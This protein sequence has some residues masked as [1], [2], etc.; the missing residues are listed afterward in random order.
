MVDQ[1]DD[2]AW[3]SQHRAE[4]CNDSSY[5]GKF[6]LIRDREILAAFDTCEEAVDKTR[7]PLGE[8]II[9]ECIPV[10]EEMRQNTIYKSTWLDD[11]LVP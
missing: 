1:E 7:I 11:C 2:Y 5:R 9:Q 4:W 6:L 8:F 10:E 3:F